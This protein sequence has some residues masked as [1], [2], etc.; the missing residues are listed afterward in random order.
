M[1]RFDIR[2]YLEPGAKVKLWIRYN[3]GEW[4]E[5]GEIR[6]SRMKTFVLPVV[7]KRCDHLQFKMTG[8]G[9]IRVYSISRIL[10]EGSDGGAY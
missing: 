5:K 9:T 3:D 10:E 4:E 2:M 1:S 6:G 7:P 8:K